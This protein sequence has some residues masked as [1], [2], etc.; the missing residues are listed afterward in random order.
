MIEQLSLI[1]ASFHGARHEKITPYLNIIGYNEETLL[2]GEALLAKTNA[3]NES[4]QNLENKIFSLKH[5]RNELISSANKVCTKTW[6]LSAI[7]FGKKSGL[8]LELG[9]NLNRVH[10]SRVKQ[11]IDQNERFYRNISPEI[12]VKLSTCGYSKELL[13]EEEK[14]VDNIRQI[15]KE[16]IDLIASKKGITLARNEARKELLEWATTFYR[17]L[18]I[19]IEPEAQLIEIMGI[20]APS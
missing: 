1:G 4:K 20:L 3:L 13:N 17:M 9:L 7:L 11:W 19:V 12:V 2:E 6:K 14:L 16:R 10:P 15:Q 18:E 5:D 8:S